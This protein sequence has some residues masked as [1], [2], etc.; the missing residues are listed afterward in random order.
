MERCP[1]C[2]LRPTKIIVGLGTSNSIESHLCPR[3]QNTVPRLPG[4][5][6]PPMSLL[7]CLPRICP[8]RLDAML[9]ATTEDLGVI[10]SG[11]SGVFASSS[12]RFLR[13]LFLFRA[14]PETS[15]PAAFLT[16]LSSIFL[17]KLARLL[18]LD[19]RNIFC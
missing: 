18:N 13:H 14:A 15:V 17:L 3:P 9:H 10:I 11:I 19:C 1:S 4:T 12:G 6:Y 16:S 2:D 7:A 8:V 5:I